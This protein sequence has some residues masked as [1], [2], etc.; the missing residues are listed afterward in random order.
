MLR[1]FLEYFPAQDLANKLI[2][3]YF[4][5]SNL[6][7]PLLHLPTFIRQ[8]KDQLHHRNIWFTGVC[9]LVFA[10]GSRW[11]NDERTLPQPSPG[12]GSKLDWRR[13]GYRYYEIVVGKLN[14]I[15]V[16]HA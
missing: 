9:L 1:T 13:A 5:H 3:L 4:R 11:C 8:W 6:I 2:D 7:F 14:I 10:I 12:E 15:S 16:L